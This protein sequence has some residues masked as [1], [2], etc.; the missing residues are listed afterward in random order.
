MNVEL[1]QHL[2]ALTFGQAQ[3]F[4]HITILPIVAGLNHSPDYLTLGEAATAWQISITETSQAGSVPELLV[5]NIAEKPVLLL[6]GE[7]LA[8]AKQNRV[9][10]TTILL[11]E[12]SQTRIPVSCTESGRWSYSSPAFAP[13][14]LVMEKEIRARKSRSVSQ[15]LA[16]KAQY[17][18]DQQEVWSG[19][20]ALHCKA[21]SS[22]P[23][24][25]M[26]DA[27]KAYTDRLNHALEHFPCQPNQRG[28]LVIVNGKVAGFD[29]LSR[30]EAYAKL[31]PKLLRSYLLHGLLAAPQPGVAITTQPS[32]NEPSAEAAAFLAELDTA[33]ESKFQSVG[34]GW[35]FRLNGQLIA[36]SALMHEGSLI[37]GAFFHL[38]TPSTPSHQ[39]STNLASLAERRRRFRRP[40]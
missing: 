23:T 25:A 17:H 8:G 2:G 21:Q 35:D 3:T 6:D 14:D 24:S 30:P 28:L 15:S 1:K 27:F 33:T 32:T 29:V 4:D 16:S 26:A 31:H 12:K 39:P 11:R 40:S 37:H 38:D 34:Y 9:L 19:I 22:S 7:E 10:N 13:A 36:G 5:T 20:S 18:S